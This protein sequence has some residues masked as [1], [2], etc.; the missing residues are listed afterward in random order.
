MAAGTPSDASPWK[1]NVVRLG[2]LPV[3]GLASLCGFFLFLAVISALGA[4]GAGV[5]AGAV[6]ACGVLVGYWL[7]FIRLSRSVERG[8]AARTEGR[9]FLLGTC[10]LVGVGVVGLLST[11]EH[12]SEG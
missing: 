5:V 7:L 10:L 6:V 2:V 11:L 12:L 8:E 4:S 1:Q 3:G 9:I